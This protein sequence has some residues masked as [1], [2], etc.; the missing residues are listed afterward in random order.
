MMAMIK[1]S[2]P[3]LEGIICELSLKNFKH[4]AGFKP[5][6]FKDGV[7]IRGTIPKVDFDALKAI[8]G[9]QW[10]RCDSMMDFM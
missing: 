3:L 4:D 8:N 9:L 2:E 6:P 7:I 10:V 1:C 5:V